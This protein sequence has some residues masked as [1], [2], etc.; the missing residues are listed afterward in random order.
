M[1]HEFLLDNEKEILALTEKKA[2]DLAGAGPTSEQLEQGLPIF[3]KQLMGV[4]KLELDVTAI[5]TVAKD[6]MAQ[7]ARE[8]DEPAMA[9]ASGRHGEEE[10]AKSAGKHGSE[11]LRLGYTLSHVVHAYGAM[12]QSINDLAMSKHTEISSN[13]FRT[14]NQCLDVAIAGAVTEFAT[15]R[16]SQKSK[17]DV[18]QLGFLAHELRNSLNTVTMAFQLIKDGTVTASGSTGQMLERGLLRLDELI[19]RSLTEVRLKV[20]P[21]IQLES[22]HLLQLVDQIA[23]TAKIQAKS[24][25]QTL[26]IRIDPA[27]KFE[28]DQQ[29]MHSALS[30]LIQNALKFTHDG[31]NIQVRGNRVGENIVVEVEDECGG[32]SPETEVSL[33]K[34]FEQHNENRKGLGLGLTITERAIVLNHGNIEC[35]NLPGKGCI[36]RITLPSHQ[37]VRRH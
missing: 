10:L 36:F 3:Y 19:E 11:L 9:A 30:N 7:A 34:P 14:L 17:R 31:G 6:R 22:M 23:I 15:Q 8:S 28:A 5:S 20:D 25:N 12:C 2:R 13:E 4:L 33:F 26:Q 37:D 24:R 32:L 1:L 18:E 21:K 16:D 27:L 35:N 29:L